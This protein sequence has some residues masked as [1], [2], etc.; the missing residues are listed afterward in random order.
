MALIICEEDTASP[1][2]FKTKCYFWTFFA[3]RKNQM[4]KY[5][6]PEIKLAIPSRITA[7]KFDDTS[8]YRFSNLSELENSELSMKVFAR[9]G[10]ALVISLFDHPK[11]F[12]RL[13]ITPFDGAGAPLR[14]SLTEPA[15]AEDPWNPIPGADIFRLAMLLSEV[16]LMPA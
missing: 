14:E 2:S 13:S 11:M 4:T 1:R 10:L 9:F 12:P 16:P 8:E 15:F 5:A 7:E 6:S 3:R